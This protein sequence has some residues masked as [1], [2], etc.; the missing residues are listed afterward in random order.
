M[1]S[2]KRGSLRMILPNGEQVILGD[3]NS[4]Y[5]VKF[6]SALVHVKNPVFFKNQYYMVILVS[7]NLT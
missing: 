3:P 6:H 5:D 2:M 7:L 1:S 4:S